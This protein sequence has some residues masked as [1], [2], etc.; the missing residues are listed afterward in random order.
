M[1]SFWYDT[2]MFNVRCMLTERFGMP[3]M[4]C[5]E[6]R[7]QVKCVHLFLFLFLETTHCFLFCVCTP[8][9]ALGLVFCGLFSAFQTHLRRRDTLTIIIQILET[10][11]T[12]PPPVNAFGL[13]PDGISAA[14]PFS[15]LTVA[16]PCDSGNT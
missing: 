2:W 12:T 14:A 1:I 8:C 3:G 5:S 16:H 10:I 7:F 6:R 9:K 4:S 13:L 11:S 15:E